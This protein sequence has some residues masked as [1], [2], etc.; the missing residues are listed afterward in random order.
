MIIL[1][2]GDNRRPAGV[3]MSRD[4]GQRLPGGG[5]QRRHDQRRRVR[6]CLAVEAHLHIESVVTGVR[7]ESTDPL[8]EVDAR[9]PV[10]PGDEI[11]HRLDAA[12][13]PAPGRLVVR[14]AAP[15]DAG[16]RVEHRV[17]D[18]PFPFPPIAPAG[19]GDRLGPQPPGGGRQPRVRGDRVAP[20]SG[21]GQPEHQADRDEQAG[22][23]GHLGHR[24]RCAAELHCREHCDNRGEQ[25]GGCL[26]G[27]GDTGSDQHP[28]D[29]GATVAE[30]LRRQPP[31][32][33]HAEDHR[34]DEFPDHQPVRDPAAHGAT[35]EHQVPQHGA[36]HRRETLGRPEIPVV[37]DEDVRDE[38]EQRRH[39]HNR[40]H[41]GGHGFQSVTS[42]AM[43]EPSVWTFAAAGWHGTVRNRPLSVKSRRW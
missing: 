15:S 35:D 3:G 20:Q 30:R 40:Q 23:A 19:V 41:S 39:S 36:G 17:V 14:A 1:A 26:P 11:L 42:A 7:G 38:D 24:R 27:S 33:T 18:D 31:G 9:I 28:V 34:R 12:R 8:G 32:G 13:A 16:E 10:V 43:H 6:A 29:P 2:V 4:V 37:P 25:D 5:R 22:G 21:R